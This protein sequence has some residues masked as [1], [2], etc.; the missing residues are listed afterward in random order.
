[1]SWPLRID[2]DGLTLRYHRRLPW[3]SISRIGISRSYL[4]GHAREVRIH[5]RSGVNKIPLRGLR[6]GEMVADTILTMFKRTRGRRPNGIP[7]E[8]ES[9]EVESREIESTAG[10]GH[11]PIQDVQVARHQQ[12]LIHATRDALIKIESEIA[13][14]G[15]RHDCIR[16]ERVGRIPRRAAS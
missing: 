16:G 12:G 4:D 2:A 7:T 11:L 13:N 1:L 6:D 3:S 8:I 15:P 10:G 9:G 5:H 14:E